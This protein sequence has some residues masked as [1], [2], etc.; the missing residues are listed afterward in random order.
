MVIA[1]LNFMVVIE[2]VR[3]SAFRHVTVPV[4]SCLRAASGASKAVGIKKLCFQRDAENTD[5]KPV[6]LLSEPISLLVSEPISQ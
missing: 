2:A 3:T 5:C 1:M 6:G 4:P